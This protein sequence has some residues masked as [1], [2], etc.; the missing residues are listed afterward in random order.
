MRDQMLVVASSFLAASR[1]PGWVSPPLTPCMFIQWDFSGLAAEHRLLWTK[2]P[3][4]I[5]VLYGPVVLYYRQIPGALELTK[6]RGQLE[7]SEWCPAAFLFPLNLRASRSRER[8]IQKRPSYIMQ[9]I[10][11]SKKKR[12]TV[13]MPI[14]SQHAREM[15]SENCLKYHPEYVPG[16]QVNKKLAKPCDIHNIK[17]NVKWICN[18]LGVDRTR[19]SK[20]SMAL[21]LRVL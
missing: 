9:M 12:I 3:S 4:K 16:M 19:N 15:E 5:W 7:G 17:L 21:F 1:P 6:L 13:I 20:I 2:N 11:L 14:R 8:C 10:C 18:Y